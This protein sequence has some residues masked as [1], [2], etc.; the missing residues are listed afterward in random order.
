MFAL[1]LNLR[2]L[3]RMPRKQKSTEEVVQ[4]MLVDVAMDASVKAV[5]HFGV[6][7]LYVAANTVFGLLAWVFVPSGSSYFAYGIAFAAGFL[8]LPLLRRIS[9]RI[10]RN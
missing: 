1:T 6:S 7:L 4:D 10:A 2:V 3:R 8:L 9:D 5:T